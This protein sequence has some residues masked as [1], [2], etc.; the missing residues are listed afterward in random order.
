MLYLIV[1]WFLGSL[2]VV[3]LAEDHGLGD[4]Y[5]INRLADKS[6]KTVKRSR[7]LKYA[8]AGIRFK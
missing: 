4:K 8:K 2:L 1:A 6:R 5:W 7:K 3:Y